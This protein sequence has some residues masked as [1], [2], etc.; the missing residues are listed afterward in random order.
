[1][2]VFGGINCMAQLMII[3]VPNYYVR[4]AGYTLMGMSQLKNGVSYVWLFESVETKHKS[5]VCGIMN[6]VDAATIGV[7]CFYFMHNPNWFPIEMAMTTLSCTCCL[8][9]MIFMPE[10]PKWC[11]IKGDR[12]GALKSFD[13][14][15][16]LNGSKNLIPRH[17]NFVEFIIAKNTGHHSAKNEAA[18]NKSIMGSILDISV[19]AT[20]IHRIKG[21]TPAVS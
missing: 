6:C 1:M 9:V 13:T 15:A 14:I 18:A 3:F 12:D 21:F 11:L 7:L 4:M 2:R 8:I 16:R 17:A 20:S 5:T 19:K 10:S